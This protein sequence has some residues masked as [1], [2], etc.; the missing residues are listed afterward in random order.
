MHDPH[1]SHVLFWLLHSAIC[2]PD[3]LICYHPRSS[4]YNS[5]AV[6]MSNPLLLF[7]ISLLSFIPLWT[8][9]FFFFFLMIRRPPRSPL[10]PYTTLFRS[11]V[12]T[13][14]PCALPLR[15]KGHS[16]GPRPLRSGRRSRRPRGAWRQQSPA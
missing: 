1:Q 13:A 9:I 7:T 16:P 3:L 2:I 6:R 14:A 5:L 15:A 8:F 10:F 11:A 12:S 4:H